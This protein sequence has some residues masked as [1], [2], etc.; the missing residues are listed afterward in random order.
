[1]ALLCGR[2]HHS[3]AM[4]CITELATSAPGYTS[5]RPNNKAPLTETLK[6]NGY[7]T[8][9]FGKCHEVADFRSAPMIGPFDQWPTSSGFEHFYGL[10]VVRPISGI[11]R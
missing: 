1:M 10:S 7:S 9:Q 4:G 5:L 8:A 3:V 6:L 2:N 11:P